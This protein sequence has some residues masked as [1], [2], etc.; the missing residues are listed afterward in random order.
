[1]NNPFRD[2]VK[3]DELSPARATQLFVP[4][5]SPIWS[6]VQNPINQIIV[7]PRGAG[8]TI[9]LRQLD[10]QTMN[11]ISMPDGYFGIYIQISRISTT[12]QSLFDTDNG[13]KNQG[14][15]NLFQQ[16]FSD[17]VW[18]EILRE[19]SVLLKNWSETTDLEINPNEIKAISGIDADSVEDLEDK[20]ME[21]QAEIEKKIQSWSISSEFEWAPITNL[22][23][24]LQRCVVRLRRLLPHLH[25]NQPC[26]FLLFDESSPIPYE[27]QRVLNGLLNRGRFYC[28]KLA[29]RP[30]EWECLETVSGRII[31]LDTDVWPLHIQYPDELEDS[32]VG[33]MSEVVNRV[34]N[35]NMVDCDLNFADGTLNIREIF[36]YDS[37]YQ[38]SGFKSVCAASS[39]NPQNLLQICSNIFAN[40]SRKETNRG[41]FFPPKEQDQAVR[42]WSKEYEDRNPD[43]GSRSLCRAL[44]RVIRSASPEEKTIG[45]SYEHGAPD[46][47]TTEYIPAE[48]G[49]RL[50]SAFAAGFLRRSSGNSSSLFEV[51]ANFHLSRGLLPR[52]NLSLSLPIRPA[53][54]IDRE[55]IQK[56][57]QDHPSVSF[58]TS[59][60]KIPKSAFLSTSFSPLLK[61]ERE[62]V[63]RHLKKVGIECKDVEDIAGDQ[64]LFTSI[65]KEIKNKDITILNTTILRPYTMLELGFCAGAFTPKGVI[66][67][68]N[69]ENPN[70]IFDNIPEFLTK[71]HILSFSFEGKSLDELAAGIYRR[72]EEMLNAPSEFSKVVVTNTSL[73]PRRRDNTVFLSLPESSIRERAIEAVRT[74]LGKVGWSVVTEDDF[75]AVWL[76][77]LQ[78]AIQCSF[79][80]RIGIVDTS[81]N[82]GPDLLQ[83]YKLVSCRIINCT[84]N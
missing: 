46:L 31:E 74:A 2:V 57:A 24:A 53:S 72:A 11:E 64:F 10:H 42:A 21:I 81:G 54:Q 83:C 61:Q 63:K 59:A 73:R 19:L 62:D 9:A 47:F 28:V 48:V 70:N 79:V 51:P 84:N 6:H 43:S 8:K 55:F 32:Y 22:P 26:L 69:E 71:I 41:F 50:Q 36:P 82:Q 34:L 56:H 80:S 18:M 13:P 77:E 37:D 29:V 52:E 39:G 12:F 14:T 66:C 1:M 17:H 5:A 65:F 78:V 16:V 3:A 76:N 58:P 75:E 40:C 4:E 20:C 44:L 60:L 33:H 35:A 30:F 23:G 15:T 45:F 25:K 7:G 38:Y 49:E 68:I 67:V 27:C